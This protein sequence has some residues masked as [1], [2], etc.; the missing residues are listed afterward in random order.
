MYIRTSLRW[1]HLMFEIMEK[2]IAITGI[3]GTFPKSKNVSEFYSNLNEKKQLFSTTDTT[4]KVFVSERPFLVGQQQLRGDFDAGF[5][6]I[7]H[8]EA[9]DMH[10]SCRKLLELS[11]EAVIDSGTNPRDLKNSK[12]G[13][14]V[15]SPD[16]EG[17]NDWNLRKVT[18]PNFS[19]FGTSGSV[20]AEK[21]SYHLQVQGP[22]V[23]VDSGCASSLYALDRAVKCILTGECDNA[24]VCGFYA[25]Q[26]P[27]VFYGYM[28]LGVLKVSDEYVN[29][30]DENCVGYVKGEATSAIFLQKLQN[31]KRILNT[32]T[33][34]DGFKEMGILHPSR[35]TIAEVIKDA[36]DEIGVDPSC[37]DFVE[38]HITG[39]KVGFVEEGNAIEKVFCSNRTTPLPIGSLKSNVGH[40]EQ[41]CGL[42]S[43]IKVSLR[44]F[45]LISKVTITLQILV[46]L[47]HNCI[48]PSCDYGK[49][50]PYV[51]AF[52]TGKITVP[53]NRITLPT[54]KDVII[55]CTSSGLGGSNAHIVLKNH[56]KTSKDFKSSYNKRLVC[57]SARTMS[58]LAKIS[59]SFAENQTEEYFALLQ[60]LFRRSLPE[61]NV[62]GYVIIEN[63][64]ISKSTH[65][66]CGEKLPLC[67]VYPSGTKQWLPFFKCIQK[68]ST[69]SETIAR[70][71]KVLE[72]KEICVSKLW[73]ALKF[74]DLFLATVVLQIVVTD[75]VRKLVSLESFHVYGFSSGAIVAAYAKEM[76]S[77]EETL[78]LTLKIR[79]RLKILKILRLVVGPKKDD[80]FGFEP[81]TSPLETLGRLYT[82]G[83][84]LNLE[85]LYPNISFPVKAPFISPLIQWKSNYEWP[86]FKYELKSLNKLMVT[87]DLD[88]VDWKFLAGHDINGH[89]LFPASAYLV[90]AWECY[91]KLNHLV[92][93]DTKII[94]EDVKFHRMTLLSK[95]KTVLLTVDYARMAISLK[96]KKEMSV[97][98]CEDFEHNALQRCLQKV[99]TARVQ[100]QSLLRNEFC[101]VSEASLDGS[102]GLI[103]WNNW[104]TFLD[105]IK[106]YTLITTKLDQLY[107]PLQIG[108]LSIDPQIHSKALTSNNGCLPIYYDK[109]SSI[110]RTPGVEL[111]ALVLSNI[112]KRLEEHPVLETY[113]FIPLQSELS[114]EDSVMVHVQLIVENLVKSLSVVNRILQ[115]HHCFV[116]SREAC[117]FESS[118]RDDIL[119][120]HKTSECSFVLMRQECT[121][122]K[123]ILHVDSDWMWL[124]ELK[125]ALNRNENILVIDENDATSGIIGLINCLKQE[126]GLNVSCMFLP[127]ASRRFDEQDE[128]FRK[129][130]R[131][132]LLINVLRDDKWGTYRHLPLRPALSSNCLHSVCVSSGNDLSNVHY[133][134]GAISNT[135]FEVY[136]GGVNFKDVMVGIGKI[137]FSTAAEYRSN[138]V[139][140]GFEFSGKDPRGSKIMGASQNCTFTHFVSMDK[141]ITCAVPEGWSLE[142]AATVPVTYLTVLH[143]L[144]KVCRL[145]RSQSVLVHSGTGGIGL[146]TINVCLHFH[147][148]IFVTVG[149]S[150]K[151]NY[152]RT[153]YPDIPDFHI[154]CSRDTTFEQM[155]M[156]HTGGR[157]VDVV[158]N[159]LS[160]DKLQAS[161]RCLTRRGIF[162]ELGKYD[163]Q[164]NNPLPITTFADGRTYVGVVLDSYY[165]INPSKKK[166]LISLLERGLKKGYVKPLPRIVY[167]QDKVQDALTYMS[168]GN[169]TGKILLKFK[170]ESNNLTA[171]IKA[172]RR[173][174]CNAQKVYVIVGGL[175]GFG[176]EL[177]DWLISRGARKVVLVSRN[178]ATDGYQHFKLKQWNDL[179][180]KIL[181]SQDDLTDE[182]GCAELLGKSNLLGVV[183]GI[184]I[185][186]VVLHDALFEYQTEET[187][188]LVFESKSVII[189]NLDAVSRTFCPF[190]SR[191]VVFSS[192]ICGRGNSG[193]ANYGMAN[194]VGERICEKRKSEGLPALAI[195]WG[196]IG[197]VGNQTNI[198]K[199]SLFFCQV[200]VLAEKLKMVFGIVGVLEQKISSC[201]NVIDTLL[202][203][204][205]VIVSSTV[206]ES[207][208]QQKAVDSKDLLTKVAKILDIANVK[209]VSLYS[210]LSNLGMDSTTSTQLRNFLAK[211]CGMHFTD[212]ELRHM[213]LDTIMQRNREVNLDT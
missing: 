209:H 179:G 114:L 102:V 31:A 187:F 205:D 140:L 116:L 186:S 126:V 118:Q 188:R 49:I 53:K 80:E 66:Y 132:N 18:S 67:L 17:K 25:V 104:T 89:L 8:R 19:V 211:E 122:G 170:D 169:H 161:V 183:D 5:F 197:E 111:R 112:K 135:C 11:V 33:N 154:G 171:P 40:S 138:L 113:K 168:T 115:N 36:Y 125:S 108:Q 201:L 162:V 22:A 12:T 110:V 144:M 173:Y 105:G 128:F 88:H 165:D 123:K 94:F 181:L 65:A 35:D 38:G 50:K 180:C 1:I 176:L 13:V 30:F 196:P 39:T 159:T 198:P 210:T 100:L 117:D 46:G 163:L 62:R 200:G 119:S 184:F 121:F 191:F 212:K 147:C 85:L 45:F 164:L 142:D 42:S 74:G 54:D 43:V 10:P 127:N 58:S 178:G 175:G 28:L 92:K 99:A 167:D 32:K 195:Q 199:I 149:S 155:V 189:K 14:F 84:D 82:L 101:C 103:K 204:N 87:I 158:I 79:K 71:E 182:N 78:L 20:L 91:L 77:L 95:H 86:V 151:R 24:L 213:T 166:Q 172:V 70:I 174:F 73:G 69:A 34:S 29:V 48:L 68:F 47:Q 208:K 146:S 60:N 203:Q 139:K 134:E 51:T 57:F 37:V 83:F 192:Y 124:E 15:V 81:N 153:L 143:A 2:K 55:G 120:V 207:S 23:T 16:V 63:K 137:D 27:N 194:S 4:W 156:K 193:Q 21:I 129:Q 59:E 41:A 150:V 6:G 177:I 9:Q 152:L 52:E 7:H 61:Y 96:S 190:L 97:W 75:V 145:K 130:L 148:N 98:Y 133:V 206:F 72:P 106:H 109:S 26:N 160:E 93:Q 56:Y 157:G 136:Y 90:V 107:V 76:L 141:S 64:N 185:L 131:K 202:T 44:F 3:A